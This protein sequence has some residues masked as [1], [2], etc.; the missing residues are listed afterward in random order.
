MPA[1]YSAASA[2]SEFGQRLYLRLLKISLA[3]IILG[4]ALSLVPEEPGSAIVGP[5]GGAL[6]IGASLIISLVLRD[7]KYERCWYGGRAAAESIKTRVWLYA[8]C[9]APYVR[10]LTEQQ[11]DTRFLDD[12][13]AILKEREIGGPYTAAEMADG[14]QITSRMRQIRALSAVD[15][16]QVYLNQ[17]VSDQ[18]SW[19]SRKAE[20]SETAQSR[21]FWTYIGMQAIAFVAA[22]V[23]LRW[24]V[25]N[26]TSVFA[27]AAS[28]V[29]AWLQARKHQELAQAYSVAAAELGLIAARGRHVSTEKDLGMFV[30]DAENA[31]SRE[32]TLWIARR[33]AA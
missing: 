10:A 23:R 29:M 11:A 21:L 12:L 14:E 26:F 32:H 24:P 5:L 4:T 33:Q 9:G 19:Y 31:I 6:L 30:A 27:A 25:V 20:H 8:V 17:R 28:A 7:Q 15:R 22:L 3:L 13:H 18:K 2:R 16:L 1:L